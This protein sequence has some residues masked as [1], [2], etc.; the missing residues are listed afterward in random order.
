MDIRAQLI[1]TAAKVWHALNEDGPQ[2]LGQLK[3]RLNGESKLLNFAV[4]WLARE[5]KIE[6]TPDKKTFRLRLR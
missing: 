5:G 4:G 6:L 3:K 1:E 2:T